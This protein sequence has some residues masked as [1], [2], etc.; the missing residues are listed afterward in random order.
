VR[1]AL[2][3]MQ[4]QE[5]AL[6][7]RAD[8]DRARGQ[9][10]A[11]AVE[12]LLGVVARFAREAAREG[13]RHLAVVGRLPGDGVEHAAVG[14]A[15][16]ALRIRLGDLARALELHQRPQAVADH[17]AEERALGTREPLRIDLSWKLKCNT[18]GPLRLA[19]ELGP[20]VSG[21]AP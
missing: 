2:G 7:G 13:E 19:L 5:A 14:E 20:G 11:V 3:G 1:F 16:Y 6:G 9:P 21:K 18:L 4:P 12:H 10:V 17:L 8:V 15:A